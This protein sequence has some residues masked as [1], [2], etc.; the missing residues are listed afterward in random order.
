MLRI[1]LGKRHYTGVQSG[2]QSRSQ[3]FYCKKVLGFVQPICMGIRQLMLQHNMVK[4]LSFITSSQNGM[5]ILMFLIMMEEALCTGLHIRV[6]LIV[7]G[8]CY[9]WMHIGDARTKRVVPL[10]IGLLLGAT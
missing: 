8:F 4:Q 6:L 9:F 3:N 2:V 1:L 10:S 7:Y 5:L